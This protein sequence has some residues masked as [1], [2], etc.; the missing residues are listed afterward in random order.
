MADLCSR[1]RPIAISSATLVFALLFLQTS[2]IAADQVAVSVAA[3]DLAT[4]VRRLTQ[5]QLDNRARGK[6]YSLTREYKVFGGDAAHPRTDVVA[7]VNFLPPNLKTYDIDQSTGGIGE[8][9]IRHILD[10]EIE[11]T[12]NPD[13]MLVTPENYDFTLAGEDVAAGRPCYRLEIAPKHQRKDLIKATVWVDKDSFRI[14]RIEGEPVRSPSFW[15][16]DIHLI[17]E[18]SEVAGMW[19]QTET[20]ALARMR[21][22]GE[23]KVTSQNLNYDVARSVAANTRPT[24]PQRRRSAV[25]AANMR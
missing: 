9:V 8:K 21:F 15:V 23:Y 6:A 12:R 3:P 2:A 16:K 18:F 14:L 5:A 4:I 20:H 25:I 24:P 11:A 13:A 10:R 7:T 1:R 22:G 19:M 17:L